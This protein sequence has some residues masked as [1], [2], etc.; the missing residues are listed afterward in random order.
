QT[1]DFLMPAWRPG[2]YQ[3]LDFAGAVSRVGARDAAGNE[4]AVRKTGK[5]A[6]RVQTGGAE[7]RVVTL[8]YDVYANELSLRSRHVDD[9]HA[10]LDGSAIFMLVDGRRDQPQRV[11]LEL[12]AGWQVATGLDPLPG[13]ARTFVAPS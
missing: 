11:E 7:G 3:I 13:A 6:W 1:L 8:G 10:Y 4:L 12:P 2:R 5:G 9:T